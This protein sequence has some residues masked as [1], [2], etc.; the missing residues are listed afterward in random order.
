MSFMY[1]NASQYYKRYRE[2][3]QRF[4]DAFVDPLTSEEAESLRHERNQCWEKMSSDE[5]EDLSE[6]FTVAD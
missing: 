1:E 5:R 2:I 4:N 3:A 6:G